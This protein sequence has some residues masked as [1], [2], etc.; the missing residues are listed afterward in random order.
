[1][2]NSC[3][4]SI[5]LEGGRV[6]GVMRWNEIDVW[7]VTTGDVI[8]QL[9]GHEDGI[10]S[11]A[12]VDK[13]RI[14]SGSI[15][16]TVRLWDVTSGQ[17]LRVFDE[18]DNYT[19]WTL[20]M[21]PDQKRFA[22]GGHNMINVYDIESGDL[23]TTLPVAPYNMAIVNEGHSLVCG[24]DTFTKDIQVW[25]IDTAML[26]RTLVGHTSEISAIIVLRDGLRIVSG[27]NDMTLRVWGIATGTCLKTIDMGHGHGT[28]LC[29]LTE[30]SDGR[31]LRVGADRVMC[32][33]DI[34]TGECCLE[35]SGQHI[36]L[37]DGRVIP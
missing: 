1:M 11:L 10:E 14:L 20:Q 28:R 34:E 32:V 17:C 36:M 35:M 15:D 5:G 27:S 21:F 26:S 18:S 19:S 6:A 30:L 7:D 3:G 31:V 4:N 12:A 8:V 2:K 29:R 13:D 23:Q 16:L 33:W 9:R 37:P 24:A 25:D 22:S